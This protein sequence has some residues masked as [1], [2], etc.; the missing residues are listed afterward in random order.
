VLD[1]LNAQQELLSAQ[2]SLVS[3]RHD[4]IIAAYRIMSATGQ[5]TARNLALGVPL[6]D[7]R[8][9]YYDDAQDWFGTG[10]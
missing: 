7:P 1:I 5:L 3:A 10:N 9:H 8:E 4:K 6:Y 2:V